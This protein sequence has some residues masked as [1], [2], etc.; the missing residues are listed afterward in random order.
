MGTLVTS[1]RGSPEKVGGQV[2]SA[3]AESSVSL[4]SALPTS[5]MDLVSQVQV[6]KNLLLAVKRPYFV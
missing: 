6:V 5:F 4:S 2:V 3:F 1:S